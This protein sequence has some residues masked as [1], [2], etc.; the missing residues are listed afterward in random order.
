VLNTSSAPVICAIAVVPHDSPTALLIAAETTTEL[1]SLKQ[2][3]LTS[4]VAG[5]GQK[6][7]VRLRTTDTSPAEAHAPIVVIAAMPFI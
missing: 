1:S 6:L 7:V 3:Q 4:A 2:A 5:A